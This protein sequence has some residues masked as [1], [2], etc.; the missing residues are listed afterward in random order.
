[1]KYAWI[2]Q[3]RYVSSVAGLCRLLQVSRTGYQQWLKRGPSARALADRQI[4]ERIVES[5]RASQQTFGRPRIQRDLRAQGYRLGNDRVRRLMRAAHVRSVHRRKHIVTTR[6]DPQLRAA[7]NLLER[8]FQA[9]AANQVWLG[10]ITYIPTGQGTL[11]LAAVLDLY[12][13]RIVGWSMSDS[14]PTSLVCNA[15]TM[16]LGRRRPAPGLIHHSDRGHQYGSDQFRQLLASHRI[17]QSMSKKGDAWDNA[18]M[19]SWFHTL[20]VER[21]H[22]LT[23]RT[24]AE[25][26]A[27]LVDYIEG[28]YNCRRRH[29][30]NDYLSPVQFESRWS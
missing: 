21:V 29:S 8:R 4:T 6:S 9:Q 27:D 19:E 15:L 22:R 25:A 23:Y 24:Y 17:V 12:S 1:M 3:Y 30:A 10:D 16:A 2:K 18:P 14:M 26:R 7:P 13:R 5:H 20:K 11:Y 28:F